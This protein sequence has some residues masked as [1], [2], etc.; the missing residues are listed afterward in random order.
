[1]EYMFLEQ[2]AKLDAL[3]NDKAAERGWDPNDL[4]GLTEDELRRIEMNPAE[5]K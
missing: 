4:G 5:D 1:M 3:S 2:H